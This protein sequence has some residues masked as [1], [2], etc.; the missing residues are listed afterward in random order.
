MKH[1]RNSI[2]AAA[3]ILAAGCAEYYQIV[4]PTTGRVYYSTKID[5]S[6]S[7]ATVFTDAR[8]GAKV[9][10]Q[11]SEISTLTEDQFNSGKN[12]TLPVTRP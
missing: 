2:L 12:Q 8:T 7:G 3:L 10:I 11:N 4:D 5:Q 6:S 1:V 9:T